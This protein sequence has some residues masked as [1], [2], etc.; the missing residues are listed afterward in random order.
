MIS[1]FH[2]FAFSYLLPVL[3][4]PF[5]LIGYLF[6]AVIKRNQSRMIWLG[7]LILGLILCDIAYLMRNY[8]IFGFILITGAAWCFMQMLLGQA[9]CA[10]VNAI[11]RGLNNRE[12]ES[13]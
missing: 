3:T 11:L 4:L 8:N 9:I 5:M 6:S 12:E 10:L 13:L 2:G 7:F 1:F